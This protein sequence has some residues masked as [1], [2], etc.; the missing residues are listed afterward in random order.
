M[1]EP[2]SLSA[3][4]KSVLAIESQRDKWDKL[5]RNVHRVRRDKMDEFLCEHHNLPG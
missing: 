1:P 5:T 3:L 2:I 4:R